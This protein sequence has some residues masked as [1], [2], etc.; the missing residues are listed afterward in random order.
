MRE[1]LAPGHRVD[2]EAQRRLERGGQALSGVERAPGAGEH[3]GARVALPG[4]VRQRRLDGGDP[5]RHPRRRLQPGQGLLGD[6]AEGMAV[7]S[8]FLLRRRRACEQADLRRP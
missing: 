5:G 1:H 3:D 2:G 7:P 6:L 8:A 4:D